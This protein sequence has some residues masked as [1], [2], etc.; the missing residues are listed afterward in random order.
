MDAILALPRRLASHRTMIR[1]MVTREVR[2]RFAGTVAGF[3]WSIVNP[4]MTILVYWFI[5]SVGLRVQPIGGVPFIVVF[6]AG[7]I[8]WSMFTEALQGG[9][10]AITANAHLATKTVFPTEILPI[11][12]LGASFVSHGVMLT[13]LLVCLA[14]H[15]MAVDWWALQAIYYFVGL[16][17]FTLGLS[18]F[19]AALHVF[20]RDTREAVGVMLNIWFWSTPIVWGIEIVP[21]EYLTLFKL[22]PMY[23]IVTGYKS[24]FI[25]HT[26][27]WHEP[28]VA[29][30]FWTVCLAMFAGGAWMF[31]RLKPEFAEAL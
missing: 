5:F 4:L 14:S 30:W 8:P 23:Y 18:W 15:G 11:V 27:P 28:W 25:Y 19:L 16:T 2:A 13:I 29:L 22:N 7:M 17:V 24:S 31:R 10:T 12:Y 3:A 9:V 1:A 6:V 26:P 20:Y 21:P